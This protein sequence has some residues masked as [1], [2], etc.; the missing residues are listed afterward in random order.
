MTVHRSLQLQAALA[1]TYDEEDASKCAVTE[2][3]W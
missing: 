3:N 2:E 1:S